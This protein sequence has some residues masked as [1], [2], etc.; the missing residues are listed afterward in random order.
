MIK[1][2]Y[3]AEK[4]SAARRILM[5]PHPR[6]EAESIANAFHECSL[7]LHDLKRNELDDKARE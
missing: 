1:F 2:A 3:P 7:G 4:L 6:G 5:I